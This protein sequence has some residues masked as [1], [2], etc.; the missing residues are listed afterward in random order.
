MKLETKNLFICGPNRSGTSLLRKLLNTNEFINLSD[1]ELNFFYIIKNANS[2]IKLKEKLK[3]NKKFMEWVSD[4][5]FLFDVINNNYPNR[6]EIYNKLLKKKLFLN[7]KILFYGEKNTFLEFK[8]LKYFN[9]YGG[10]LCFIHIIR[11]PLKTYESQIY[12]KGEKRKINIIRWYIKWLLSFILSKYFS[13]RYKN[14]FISIKFAD[15]IYK[16]KYTE[17]K[18]NNFLNTKNIKFDEKIYKSKINSSFAF[19]K[20]IYKFDEK[21]KRFLIKYTLVPI[22]KTFT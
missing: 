14:F 13:M 1:I 19:D 12:Y 3:A 18:I 11:D 22:Y 7:N 10:K 20:N 17:N 5:D 2:K 4:Q 8:F 16:R 6:F 9:Y 15:L 21:L